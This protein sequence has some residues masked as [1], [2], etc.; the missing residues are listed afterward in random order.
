[1]KALISYIENA[2]KMTILLS[3]VFLESESSE[4][5][6]GIPSLSWLHTAFN[7]EELLSE[8]PKNSVKGRIALSLGEASC[9]T[10]ASH[11]EG[12]VEWW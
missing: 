10:F 6:A 1:M 9:Y 5:M 2:L 4:R 12:S 8:C 11:A 3:G 7:W